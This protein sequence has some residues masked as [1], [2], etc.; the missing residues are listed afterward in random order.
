MP[1]PFAPSSA[2]S[3]SVTSTPYVFAH[4]G[5]TRSLSVNPVLGPGIPALKV[6]LNQL[7]DPAPIQVPNHPAPEGERYVEVNVTI[8]NVGSATLPVQYGYLRRMLGFTWYLN[9]SHSV[10]DSGE[11]FTQAFPSATCD[12]VAQDF[13]QDDVAPGQTITGCV[14][15]GPLANAIVVTGFEASLAYGGYSDAY[16]AVWE[17][18]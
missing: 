3:T 6:T 8:A 1:V 2:T 11:T 4:V 15:F 14:Q 10:P 16:P 5:E 13:T 7:I 17:I 18:P 9:P 12:G